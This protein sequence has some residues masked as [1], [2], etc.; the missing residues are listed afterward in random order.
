MKDAFR[1]W[2][3]GYKDKCC[4][5]LLQCHSG[6]QQGGSTSTCPWYGTSQSLVSFE[7]LETLYRYKPALAQIA[8]LSGNSR[9]VADGLRYRRSLNV[10]TTAVRYIAA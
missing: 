9:V 10:E 1:S 2:N 6:C 7:V 5:R 8:G 3:I 4:R